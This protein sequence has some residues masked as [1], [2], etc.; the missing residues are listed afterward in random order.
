[1]Q[2]E[3]AKDIKEMRLENAES[4]QWF[5]NVNQEDIK[6]DFI[7]AI[8]EELIKAKFDKLVEELSINE[9][10]VFNMKKK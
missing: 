2:G 8:K 1:M 7:E 3:R 10:S 4:E 6:E 9:G 5:K